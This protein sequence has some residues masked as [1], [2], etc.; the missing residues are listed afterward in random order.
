MPTIDGVKRTMLGSI[1]IRQMIVPSRADQN[2]Q[3]KHALGAA[4]LALAPELSR[5]L[6]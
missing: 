5:F 1:I 2:I 3:S 6:N 4:D